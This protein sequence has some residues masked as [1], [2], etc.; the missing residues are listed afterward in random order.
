M[1]YLT[2]LLPVIPVIAS[3]LRGISL[4]GVTLCVHSGSNL[5]N[6]DKT[7]VNP[8]FSLGLLSVWMGLIGIVFIFKNQCNHGMVFDT[9]GSVNS[10]HNEF[11][12]SEYFV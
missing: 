5:V 4:I 12:S 6:P 8:G 7:R 2:I 11:L 1:F 3:A 10:Y 9:Y